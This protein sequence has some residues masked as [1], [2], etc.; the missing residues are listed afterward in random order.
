MSYTPATRSERLQ[1]QIDDAIAD[2]WKI[3]TETPERIVLVKRTVGDLGVHI[4]LAI[5]TAWWS[6]GLVNVVYGGYKYLN[7]SQRR[8][9]RDDRGC[10]ECGVSVPAG[11]NY[12]ANCGTDLAETTPE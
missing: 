7:D 3:E 4:V 12:C 11:A 5:L 10:P 1:R 2:G 8:V 9:L 6:F